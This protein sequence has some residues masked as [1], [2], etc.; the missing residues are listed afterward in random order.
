MNC[1]ALVET[2]LEA[3]LFGIEDRTA[4]GVR[5]RRGKFELADGGTLFHGRGVGSIAGSAGQAAESDSGDVGG[6]CGR[7]HHQA[8]GYP[9]RR[10][11]K[12]VSSRA[13]RGGS[14]PGRPV[15]PPWPVSKFRCRRC[16]PGAA[17]SCCWSI[18]S[19]NAIAMF[20]T[21]HLSRRAIDAFMTYDWPGNVR[22]LERVIERRD[23]AMA[24]SNRDYSRGSAVFRAG[25]GTTQYWRR[26]C[27][28]TIRC[29]H[30]AAATRESSSTAATRTNARPAR[31]WAS[32]T[33]R[34]RPTSPTK[35][36][37]QTSNAP[38]PRP[39]RAVP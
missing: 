10:R 13:R 17:I 35:T 33:T 2:L 24:T 29:A 25:A 26:R 7:A 6:T 11:D 8:P 39:V 34:C 16:A 23:C 32:A 15:L 12:P 18:I 3:E 36:G 31:C 22:E 27:T 20:G 21:L 14:L 9:H 30:G 38:R 5:G 28:G 4:T 19:W 1:A 37:H